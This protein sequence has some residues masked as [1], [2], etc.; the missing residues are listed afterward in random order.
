MM[1][2]RLVLAGLAFF[3]FCGAASVADAQVPAH[4]SCE[5]S[6]PGATVNGRVIELTIQYC[7]I[8]GSDGRMLFRSMIDSSG[9]P[10]PVWPNAALTALSQRFAEGAREATG[11]A[12]APPECGSTGVTATDQEFL[13]VCAFYLM[14][15]GRYREATPYLDG[16][17]EDWRVHAAMSIILSS[18]EDGFN[19]MP[20]YLAVLERLNGADPATNAILPS[21]MAQME[22]P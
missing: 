12:A 5:S 19:W 22:L 20:D 6:R 15:S 2:R 18:R 1:M 13:Q 14:G 9:R 7:G 16:L 21:M 8:R 11:G 17:G 3:A 4:A 10:L